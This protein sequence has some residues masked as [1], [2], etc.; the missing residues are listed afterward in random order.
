MRSHRADDT[1]SFDARL[2]ELSLSRLEAL[3]EW[4]EDAE[5][6]IARELLRRCRAL[7][8]AARPVLALA[9]VAAN[10]EARSTAAERDA[11]RALLPRQCELCHADIPRDDAIAACGKCIADR[12]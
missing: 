7:V 8:A 12:T 6:A 2:R 9:D 5:D 4:D 11:L 10:S 1:N 3:L